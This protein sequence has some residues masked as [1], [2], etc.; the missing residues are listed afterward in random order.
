MCGIVGAIS[1][2]RNIL[3]ILITGLENLDI[4]GMTQQELLFQKII[5]L[6]LLK[7]LVK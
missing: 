5:I 3:P 6:T 2:N 1:N 7:S 4:G